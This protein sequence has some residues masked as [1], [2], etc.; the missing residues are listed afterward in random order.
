VLADAGV[1]VLGYRAVASYRNSSQPIA[2]IARELGVDAIVS[3][4]IIRTGDVVSLSAEL[5]DA[6]SD[7]TLWS[8]TFERS[9]A[10]VMTLQRDVAAEIADGIHARLTPDQAKRLTTA[11]QVTPRA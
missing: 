8:R 5:I 1:R 7:E 10:D 4:A 11:R 6:R 2:E 3:G 9:A